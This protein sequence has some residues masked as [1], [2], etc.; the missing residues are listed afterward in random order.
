VPS[1]SRTRADNVQDMKKE[2]AKPVTKREAAAEKNEA[3]SKGSVLKVSWGEGGEGLICLVGI[4][5]RP[6]TRAKVEVPKRKDECLRAAKSL[7]GVINDDGRTNQEL[8]TN[9]S[10]SKKY[11]GGT[12]GGLRHDTDLPPTR[13]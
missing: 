3:T 6:E 12:R 1:A 2:Q 8:S 13:A 4:Q 7:N 5:Q 9:Q 11:R 10:L